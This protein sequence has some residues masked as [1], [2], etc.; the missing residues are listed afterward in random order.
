MLPTVRQLQ[1][2]IAAARSGQISRAANDMNVT[3]SSI[4]IAIRDLE[5]RLGYRLF[6]RKSK[7][8]ELTAAGQLFLQNATG[9]LAGLEDLMTLS[10]EDDRHIGGEV[11]LGVTDT[12]SGYYL[13]RI[14]RE[15][16]HRAP[17]LTMHVTELPRPEVETGVLEGRFDLGII[18]I[19]NIGNK[20]DFEQ[21]T[22]LVSQ[23]Q[24]W[25]G[26]GHPFASRETLA[27]ADLVDQPYFL[28]QT[29]DHE[30][31][32]TAAW[33]QH[34]F[35]P[36]IVFRSYSIEAIRSLVA[37]GHGITVLSDMIYRAWSLEGQ[38][39]LRKPISDH[40]STMNTGVIWPKSREMSKATALFLRILTGEIAAQRDQGRRG[41]LAE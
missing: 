9:V 7:G 18:L 40:I 12:V 11:R 19:S 27:F 24:L 23:R 39:L 21:E 8:V 10:V 1:Y 31:T 29:D 3:Q 15:I 37:A 34:R 30:H 33:E 26:A 6:H 25:V 13:P 2:F 20:D 38:R 14:W 35:Q 16:R 17:S 22:L 32:M 5:G 4:T 28:L 36:N 41:F